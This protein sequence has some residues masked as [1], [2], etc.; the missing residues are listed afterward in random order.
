MNEWMKVYCVSATVSG[1]KPPSQPHLQSKELELVKFPRQDRMK[2]IRE[3]SR[4]S[5]EF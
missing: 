4:I 2:G 3:H 5:R 1:F